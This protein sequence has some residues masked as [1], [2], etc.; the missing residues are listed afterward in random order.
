MEQIIRLKDIAKN[1]IYIRYIFGLDIFRV[2]KV[3]RSKNLEVSFLEFLSQETLVSAHT[4]SLHDIAD[5]PEELFGLPNEAVYYEEV[6]VGVFGGSFYSVND[7][8]LFPPCFF[9]KVDE[10]FWKIR[11]GLIKTN[12][13]KIFSW[14]AL[15]I[16]AN[17]KTE[18]YADSMKSVF[19][20]KFDSSDDWIKKV[21]EVYH[22]IIVSAGDANFLKVYAKSSADFDV[23]NNPLKKVER[24]IN[25][26]NWYNKNKE[27]LVWNSEKNRL[28]NRFDL[29]EK[30]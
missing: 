22:L 26:D 25:S 28:E 10:P 12:L 19:E 6:D 14:D 16:Y 17:P 5:S 8:F 20:M 13:E 7:W 4:G 2:N 1:E 9:P 30:E 27:N 24:L 11:N 21:L 29:K 15:S 18:D 23:I 3:N